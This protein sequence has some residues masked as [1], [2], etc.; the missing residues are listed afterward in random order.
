MNSELI[1]LHEEFFNVINDKIAI[2]RCEAMRSATYEQKV[3]MLNELTI[4]T[5]ELRLKILSKSKYI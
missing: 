2:E 1:T 3:K 4:K 5:N